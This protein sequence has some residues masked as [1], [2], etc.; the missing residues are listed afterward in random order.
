MRHEVLHK[1]RGV[2]FLRSSTAHTRYGKDSIGLPD[3]PVMV[4]TNSERNDSTCQRRWWYGNAVGINNE[5]TNDALRF[6][7]EIHELLELIYLYY[8][9]YN[10]KMEQRYLDSFVENCF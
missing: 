3:Y 5:R 7:S 9:K 4:V 1:P 2:E 10:K 8:N 6:G